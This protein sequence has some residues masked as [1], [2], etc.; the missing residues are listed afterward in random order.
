MQVRI[1]NNGTSNIAMPTELRPLIPVL[2]A[3]SDIILDVTD[4]Q[5]DTLRKLSKLGIV[6]TSPEVIV[7]AKKGDV[8]LSD[9][10]I[11]ELEKELGEHKK[12]VASLQSDKVKLEDRVAEL[13]TE[14]ETKVAEYEDKITKYKAKLKTL[15]ED[16]K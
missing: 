15:K 4:E 8:A 7:L 2:Q 9:A 10:R 3:E 14:L 16:T 5:V 12:L 6:V 11:G 13:E 1:T